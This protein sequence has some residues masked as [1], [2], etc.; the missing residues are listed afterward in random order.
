LICAG[1]LSSQSQQATVSGTVTDPQG[2]AIPGVEVIAINAATNVGYRST[3]NEA[4]FYSLRALPIGPYRLTAEKSGFRRAVQGELVLTTGQA[5]EL[6][7][8]LEVG[9]VTETVSVTARPS[10]IETRTSDSSQLVEAR[11]VEDIPLGDRRTMN[12][13]RLTGAAVFVNYDS[14]AK[15][16]FSIAGGRTQS[17]NFYMDGGTIQNMRLGIGQLDTD[18][19]VETVAEVKVLANSFAAEYGGSGG[20]RG[21]DHQVRDQPAP[22]L[23]LRVSA[24]PDPR[25]RQFLRARRQ[26][27]ETAAPAPLQRLWRDCRWPRPHPEG[28]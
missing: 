26:R 27:R 18:L 7:L 5:L 4:G 16:N 13:V 21:R 22:W 28:L 8:R 19:P 1:L 3:T 20:R 15:P 2:G 6:E 17:Q 14:G 23:R 12:I 9:A 11:S 25:C 10:L 24:Q